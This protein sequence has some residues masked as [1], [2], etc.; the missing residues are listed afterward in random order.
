MDAGAAAN[1]RVMKSYAK[2]CLRRSVDITVNVTRRHA[3]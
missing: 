3:M 2:H 1:S